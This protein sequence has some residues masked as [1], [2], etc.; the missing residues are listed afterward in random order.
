MSL[1]NLR[2][3]NCYQF[4]QNQNNKSIFNYVTDNTMFINKNECSDFTPPFISYIPVGIQ[5][6]NVDIENNLRGTD[7]LN[8]RCT[9]CKFNPNTYTIP[10]IQHRQECS[11]KYK[12]LPNGSISNS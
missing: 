1:N 8:T 6:L 9:S 7:K 5:Q 2:D 10:E 11:N 12:I 3:D 4:Q